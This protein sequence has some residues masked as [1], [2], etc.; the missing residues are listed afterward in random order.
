[1]MTIC[2]CSPDATRKPERPGV[3]I[4][5]GDGRI[6]TLAYPR[7]IL[8]PRFTD[9]GRCEVTQRLGYSARTSAAVE[10]LRSEIETRQDHE[11][12]VSSLFRVGCHLL[13]E[14]HA[15]SLPEAAA[16]LETDADG[17]AS[18]TSA[19]LLALRGPDDSAEPTAERETPPDGRQ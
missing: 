8:S 1:M 15:V 12:P 18:L 6:W 14:A 3:S 17:L 7:P 16:L 4:E 5:L 10:D 19:I 13:T 9:D 11:V 2:E